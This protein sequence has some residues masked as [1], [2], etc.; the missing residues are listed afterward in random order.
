M[1]DKP[2]HIL[3]I[4]ANWGQETSEYIDS[5]K[6]SLESIT[7]IECVPSMYARLLEHT[8][9]YNHKVKIHNVEALVSDTI[10]TQISFHLA[11]NDCGS[12][13]IYPPNPDEW[14]WKHVAF[15]GELQLTTTTCDALVENG[16]LQAEYDTLV[17]D[18]QGSELNVL[19]G[20]SSI[21]PHVKQAIVE[22]SRRSFYKGGVLLP[23]LAYFLG[24]NGLEPHYIPEG[25]HGDAIFKLSKN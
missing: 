20:M 22:F 17:L 21:L 10:G 14:A 7:Y 15:E 12:S 6:D 24:S 11:N 3:H 1:L 16:S 18:T 25:D 4:G 13:S 8:S 9:K 5:F 2:K 23:E 19:K